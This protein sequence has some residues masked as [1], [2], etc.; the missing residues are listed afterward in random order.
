MKL[1]PPKLPKELTHESVSAY[2]C[3]M[4]RYDRQRIERGEATSQQVQHENEIFHTPKFARIISFLP[5]FDAC[6]SPLG[7]PF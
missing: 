6:A 5:G 3:A 1:T 4:R 2:K 7:N